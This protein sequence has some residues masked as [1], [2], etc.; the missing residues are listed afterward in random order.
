MI[1][2]GQGALMAKVDIWHAYR[3]V[4]IHLDDR[5]LLGKQW[6]GRAFIDK[7]LSFGLR[8]APKIFAALS[9]ALEWILQT[10]GMAWCIHYVDNF[11]TAGASES[12]E[13]Q[14]YLNLIKEACATLGF[15]L[16]WEKVE[17]P[18]CVISFL[19][20]VL[21]SNKMEVRLP[22]EKARELQ[23]LLRRMVWASSL[24]KKRTSVID[25]QTSTCM[26]GHASWTTVPSQNDKPSITSKKTGP[27]RAS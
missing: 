5:P 8:S 6:R 2:L 3:N 26:Q 19:G 11:F 7:A 24:Q 12:S 17:G 27:L 25:W 1:K 23:V 21:D 20:I 16:K 14:S 18:S 10:R 9:D 15:P 4:P 22:D 13:C